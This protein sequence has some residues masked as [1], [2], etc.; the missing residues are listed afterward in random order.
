MGL[1]L[2]FVDTTQPKQI[3]SLTHLMSQFFQPILFSKDQVDE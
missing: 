3:K 1:G 2:D